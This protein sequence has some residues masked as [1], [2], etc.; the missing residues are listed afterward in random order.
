MENLKLL[1]RPC[2]RRAE[3]FIRADNSNDWYYQGW[4]EAGKQSCTCYFGNDKTPP[5][6]GFHIIAMT[7]E[8]QVPNQ[9]GKPT[10]PLPSYRKLSNEVRVIRKP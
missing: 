5:K 3:V 4:I 9:G 7:T 8:A 10:K 6:V 1:L 2:T